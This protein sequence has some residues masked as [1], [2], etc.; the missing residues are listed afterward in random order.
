MDIFVDGIDV[1]NKDFGNEKDEHIKLELMKFVKNYTDNKLKL[2][3]IKKLFNARIS[4]LGLPNDQNY[5]IIK[6]GE[7]VTKTLDNLLDYKTKT[8]KE[9]YNETDI[10]SMLINQD[11]NK[12]ADFIRDQNNLRKNIISNEEKQSDK[13]I[14]EY[15]KNNIRLSAL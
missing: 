2:I 14:E 13:K 8:D 3:E 5:E 12:H 11:L 1:N 15:K 9:F 6:Y 7:E 4:Q 10:K